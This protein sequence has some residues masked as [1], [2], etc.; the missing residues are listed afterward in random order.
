M[1]EASRNAFAEAD[2]QQNKDDA[3]KR[4][5][6]LATRKDFDKLSPEEVFREF[7]TD[8]SGAIDWEEFKVMLPKA[9]EGLRFMVLWSSPC[10]RH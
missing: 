10:I 5:A 1:S 9:W 7:D 3:A 2:A 4:E 6:N 8:G